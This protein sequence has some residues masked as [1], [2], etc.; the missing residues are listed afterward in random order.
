MR[1]QRTIGRLPAAAA[2]GLGSLAAC[3]GAASPPPGANDGWV[4]ATPSPGDLGAT[5]EAKRVEPEREKDKG[6]TGD[7]GA[8]RC[9]YG[10]LSDPHRGFIRCLTPDERDARWLPPEPQKPPEPKEPKDAP[11]PAP[12][13]APSAPPAPPA[14]PPVVEISA[15]K[16]DNGEVPKAEK[17]VNGLSAEI[18]KC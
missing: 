8:P 3:A 17:S 18:G 1:T 9:P 10:E 13:A 5:P 6:D 12:S 7:G 16:F 15:P 4:S 2:L 11:G 14:A